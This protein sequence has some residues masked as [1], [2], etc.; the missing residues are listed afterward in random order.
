LQPIQAAG[1]EQINNSYGNIPQIISTQMAQRGYGSSGSMG[2]TMYQTQLGRLNSQSQFQG[3]MANLASQRQFSAGSLMDS[4][5]NTQVGQNQNSTTTTMDP[6]SLFSAL[7]TMLMMGGG[8]FSA[9]G[10]AGIS[11][12]QALP[13]QDPYSSMASMAAMSPSLSMNPSSIGF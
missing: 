9:G 8:G 4:M 13:G 3:Q 6:S 1:E 2:N 12:M 5:L 7:G 10:S 11:P